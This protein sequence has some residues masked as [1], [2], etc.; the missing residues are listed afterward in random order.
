MTRTTPAADGGT[1]VSQ[2]RK[3]TRP[4]GLTLAPERRHPDPNAGDGNIVETTPAGKQLHAQTAASETGA[5]SL[6]GLVIKS[7]GSGVFYVGDGDNTSSS[8]TKRRPRQTPPASRHGGLAPRWPPA[9]MP[10]ATGN[11]YPGRATA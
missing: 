1:T 9:A 2:D 11:A 6:F 8:S 4:L 5:G 3:R 7:A 10:R